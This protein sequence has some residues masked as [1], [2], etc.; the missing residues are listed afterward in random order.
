M[1]NAEKFNILFS[2]V[3]LICLF[4]LI[5]LNA[6]SD[7]AGEVSFSDRQKIL[8]KLK[9]LAKDTHTITAIVTQEKQLSL[10]KKKIYIDGSVV[11]IKNPNI[12]RW[13][14]VKPDKSIIVIEDETMTIYHP[15]VKEAQI[16]NLSENPVASN[17]VNFFRTTLWGTYHELERKFSVTILRK[18]NEIAFQLVPLSKTVGRYLSSILIYYDEGTGFPRGFE[19][20]TPKGGKTVTRLSN[21]KINPEIKTDTFKLKLPADVWI[22]NNPEHSQYD[23]K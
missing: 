8:E 5:P 9:K 21:I 12:F 16:Y 13:D 14:I 19:M 23:I 20:T 11:I 3:M 10:L 17:T 22:T 2:V 18:N 6:S 4:F 15:D 7:T 1:V